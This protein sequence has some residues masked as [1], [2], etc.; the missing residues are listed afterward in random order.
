[1]SEGIRVMANSLGEALPLE[2]ARVRDKVLP[3]YTPEVNGQFAAAMMRHALDEAAK[4]LAEGD[5]IAML[6]A[7]E[8]LKGYEA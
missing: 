6:H 1:M 5:V 8:Q 2:M 4:A 3:F 7:Y